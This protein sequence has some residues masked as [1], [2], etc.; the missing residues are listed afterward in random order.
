MDMDPDYRAAVELALRKT[1]AAAQAY[2]EA[3]RL[4]LAARLAI[5]ASREALSLAED[6]DAEARATAIV[7]G[8]AKRLGLADAPT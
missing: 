1:E 5:T 2:N 4:A 3:K 6:A 8:L 7:R